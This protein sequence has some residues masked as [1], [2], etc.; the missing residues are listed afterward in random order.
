M[1]NRRQSIT[2]KLAKDKKLLKNLSAVVKADQFLWVASDEKTSVERLTISEN[3]VFDGYV[4]KPL[5]D[6]IELPDTENSEIDLEGMDYNGGYLWLIGSHSLKREKVKLDKFD[7]AQ[8]IANLAK[9]NEKDGN[10]YILARIPLINGELKKEHPESHPQLRAAQIKARKDGNVFL[11]TLNQDKH[12]GLF[13]KIPSKDNG[14]DIEGLAVSGSR[15]FIGLRGPVLRGWAVILEIQVESDPEIPSQLILKEIAPEGQTYRKHFVDLRGMGVRDL[16]F[17]NDDLL[18]LAGPTMEMDGTIAVFRWKN[19]LLVDHESLTTPGKLFEIPHGEGILA[20]TDRAEGLTIFSTSSNCTSV[21]VTYDSPSRLR[22]VGNDSLIVDLFDLPDSPCFVRFTGFS[23]EM[24]TSKGPGDVAELFNQEFEFG[25]Q[26]ER[27]GDSEKQFD[28]T[29]PTVFLSP[30]AA[31]ER[32]YH[33]RSQPGFVYVEPQFIIPEL[34]TLNEPDLTEPEPEA[35][36]LSAFGGEEHKPGSEQSDWSVNAIQAPKAWAMFPEGKTPGQGV[37][38]GHPDTGFTDH[39][40]ILANLIPDQG[41]NFK[42]NIQDARDQLDGFHPGHGT[43]T[44]SVIVSPR[45]SVL[46]NEVDV[47]GVAPGSK[48]IP[49]RVSNTVV[50]LT[51]IFK[52]AKAI[53]YAVNQGAH[54]ISISMGGLGNWRIHQAVRYAQ[55]HGVILCAAAGNYV[56]FVAWPAAYD[57]VIGVAATNVENRPWRGSSHGDKVDV[58]APGESVW[59]ATVQHQS[60][61]LTGFSTGRGSGTS[62]AVTHVAGI[63]ALWLSFHG[64]DNLIA[65]YGQ[66]KLSFVF[67]QI[68]RKSCVHPPEWDQNQYGAGIIQADQVLAAALPVDL[69]NAAL[70]FNSMMPVDTGGEAT[71]RHLFEDS[72]PEVLHSSL[73]ELLGVPPS[74]LSR[75]LNQVGQ[76]LAFHLA[77]TPP[78]FREFRNQL[79]QS[80]SIRSA[81]FEVEP[82][83]AQPLEATRQKLRQK[84]VSSA[85]A[86]LL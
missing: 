77:T 24:A 41:F 44:A 39:P 26:A 3:S 83:H 45:Q 6:Y 75:H 55:R 37:V 20:G 38:I 42:E 29:H 33:L 66:E 62:F 56:G 68:L 53:E 49:L 17:Q 27:F 48:I 12:L 8:N 63:A 21:L 9:G 81:V 60:G 47:I 70:H 18:I 13:L 74:D 54:V 85:L 28:V 59:R 73:A 7:E 19:A 79:A 69:P 10:R 16:C 86:T 64:R 5:R 1:S 35:R 61:D 36:M 76:E 67:N 52:L 71:F 40:Q 78:L 46:P 51:D 15:V 32:T 31:W 2:L 65:R 80:H 4:T 57:E 82:I 84:G 50:L 30:E 34:P 43:G 58:S 14:F 23:V 72:P 11:D 22:K 25:W